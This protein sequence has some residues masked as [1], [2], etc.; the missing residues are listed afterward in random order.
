VKRCPKCNADCGDADKFCELDGTPLDGVASTSNTSNTSN[1]SKAA[2]ANV[3][4]ASCGA[5]EGDDGDGYCLSCGHRVDVPATPSVPQKTEPAI[6]LAVGET[7]GIYVVRAPVPGTSDAHANGP[8]GPVLLVSGA[9]DDLEREREILEHIARA[10]IATLGIPTTIEAIEHR[11][12]A[13]SAPPRGARLLWDVAPELSAEETLGLASELLETAQTLETAGIAFTPSPRDFYLD[14]DRL[15]LGRLRGA[16]RLPA[17]A[18]VDGRA[19]LETLGACLLPEPVVRGTPELVRLFLTH[20]DSVSRGRVRLA[21]ALADIARAKAS[22]EGRAKIASDAPVAAHAD[23]GMWRPYQQDATAV[24]SGQ[25]A[26]G[27]PFYVVVVCDGVSSSP[28]AGQA[29][30]LAAKAT[31]DALAHFAR[32]ADLRR[33]TAASAVNQA[34]RAA[35]LLVCSAHTADPAVEPPGTTIVAAFIHRRR[36]TIGW[37]GDSRAYWVGPH[38]CEQLTRDHSWVNDAIA[39][40]EVKDEDEVQGALAHTITKCL[41]PLEVGDIPAEVEPDV[42]SRDLTTKGLLVLCSDGLWNYASKP[43]QMGE[44]VNAAGDAPP[45]RVAHFLVCYALCR[46]GQDNV[47]VGVY[48]H[49]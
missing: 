6:T 7:I 37:V 48:A 17:N 3:A 19:L 21:V 33:E 35:H 26:D 1:T 10:R 27:E 45:D 24:A 42:R 46:G 39:R 30:T 29:S 22:L 38:G 20:Q 8:K 13:L 15:Y 28:V 31:C 18:H 49:A 43:P 11:A 9:S 32:S 41:G 34:I 23:Q 40:G 14:E 25:S 47:S 16:H 4:C 5:S 36:A 44:V 2:A 12:L